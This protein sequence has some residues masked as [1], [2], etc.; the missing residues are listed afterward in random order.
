MFTKE[1]LAKY[2]NSYKEILTVSNQIWR[3]QGILQ[4]ETV[5]MMK[6]AQCYMCKREATY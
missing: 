6:K 5:L 2:V 1:E 3:I 4:I